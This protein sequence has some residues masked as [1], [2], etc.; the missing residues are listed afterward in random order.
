MQTVV[1]Q[2]RPRRTRR[3]TLV[4]IVLVLTLPLAQAAWASAGTLDCS[5][6]DWGQTLV[7]YPST[8]ATG[9]AL[10]I[11]RSGP[12]Q[13]KIVVAIDS[14]YNVGALRLNADGSRDATFGTDGLAPTIDYFGS[15]DYVS[16]V[17]AL[18]DGTAVIAGQGAGT[19][20]DISN[21]LAVA[22]YTA[23]GQLDTTFG[24]N[25]L[26]TQKIGAANHD[27]F[28]QAMVA[29][30]AGNIYV[31]GQA[32]DASGYVRST[33]VKVDSTGAVV[34]IWYAD[35][36][37]TTY[38]EGFYGVTLQSDGKVVAGGDAYNGSQRVATV[39][40]F[41][42][43]G[44]LDSTFSGDGLFTFAYQTYAGAY[45]QVRDVAMQS[46]GK[47]IAA[48]VTSPSAATY[49]FG[50]AR[51]NSD[52]TLDTTTFANPTGMITQHV[53]TQDFV[54]RVVVQTDGQIVL[55]GEANNASGNMD[56]TLLRYSSSGSLD[57]T[58]GNSGILQIDFSNNMDRAYGL[59]QQA[60]GKLVVTGMAS[61]PGSQAGTIRLNETDFARRYGA[62]KITQ[63]TADIEPGA[64]GDVLH[65]QVCVDGNTGPAPT[66]TD[67]QFNTAGS[68][69][70]ADIDSAQVY[71]TDQ[72]TTFTTTTPFGGN[73]A[74]P[75]GSF[76][77]SGSLALSNR[78]T[79]YWL[80]YTIDP[81]AVLDGS[82]VVDAQYTGIT[83]DGTTYTPVI[84]N[85]T[86]T[87]RIYRYYPEIIGDVSWND[88]IDNV[89]YAGINN[90]SGTDDGYADYTAQVAAVTQGSS[91]VLT[92]T[93]NVGDVGYPAVVVAWVDWNHN[94]SLDDPGEKYVIGTHLG[95]L[96]PNTASATITVPATATLGTTRLRIVSNAI[97]GIV[98][99]TNYGNY[100]NWGEAEDYSVNVSVATCIA[101]GSGNWSTYF[102]ACPP[103]AKRIIPTGINLVL[104]TDVSLDGD[105]ELQGTAT[106]DATSQHHTMT[107]TG[108][109]NQTLT[110]NPLTFYNL[111]INKT[112]KTDTVTIVGKLKV[113]KKL[114]IAKGKL[115]SASDYGDVEIGTEGSLELTNDIT[116]GGT[117]LNDGE[118]IANTYQVAFDGTEPQAIGGVNQTLFHRLV[119][120]PTA[121]VFITTTP[122]V[123][124]TLEN[125]GVLSQTLPVGPEAFV[126]F[127]NIS[128]D[129]YYGV[130]ISADWATNL[131]EVTVAI[132]GN[133]SQC[134]AD[135]GSPAYRHR[136]FRIT[137][138]NDGT[139]LSLTL[140]STAGEDVVSSDDIYQYQNA[141][142]LW[143]A[144]TAVCGSNPGDFCTTSGDTNL[145]AGTNY[146]L[147]GGV[148]SPTVVTLKD[149]SAAPQPIDGVVPTGLGLLLVLVLG[150]VSWRS[151]RRS[152]GSPAAIPIKPC[153]DERIR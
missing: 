34:G 138:Q 19:G 38:P 145:D 74:N 113:T 45:E 110:G 4:L 32:T 100:T 90:T 9:K 81:A 27:E 63:N 125:Y 55:A 61:T 59:A 7:T 140:Y 8:Y 96:G 42:T 44:S 99:P 5:F 86:G 72:G 26:L 1:N 104:D 132:S 131:G 80:A 79:N 33:V 109:G 43:D 48:F 139:G 88:Y 143:A 129:K 13:G 15:W 70:P 107:L 119:I 137:T 149:L 36:A 128:G 97:D 130:D 24:T 153:G 71:T 146:F 84:T 122:A 31:A 148:D 92:T 152:H 37:G 77:A 47:I 58:F 67:F 76:T 147:I 40:R 108:S 75:N 103:G 17:A 60:D 39:A 120:S 150:V 2:L 117:W 16:G 57:T 11:Y 28:W 135:A 10:S 25:G 98:E 51:I 133:A 6:G 87:R 41:N 112:N 94:F 91:A 85:P 56:Y 118:F 89:T 3:F 14:N 22:R 21:R 73:I 65:M 105:L 46:D 144:L 124:D 95:L 141:F 12:Q 136:C 64:Q 93:I 68:T 101:T 114:T 102:A 54:Y 50:V 126:R 134:T 52:G 69:L 142:S 49:D 66:L 111:T 127:L 30:A 23:T 53:N 29:D 115:K 18:A 123:T 106:L 82:H 62:S 78:V 151:A 20:A 35:F 121:G 116:V 83:V